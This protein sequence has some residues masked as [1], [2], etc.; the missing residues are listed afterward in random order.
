MRSLANETERHDEGYSGW[1]VIAESGDVI[2]CGGYWYFPNASVRKERLKKTGK[3]ASILSAR[4][5]FSSTTSSS[6][7]D[8]ASARMGY[9]APLPKLAQT[10]Q[11]IGFWKDVAF[12]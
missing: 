6:I 8:A 11:R 10:A 4:T 5:A 2:E 3:T 1:H 9:E 12:E 7:I